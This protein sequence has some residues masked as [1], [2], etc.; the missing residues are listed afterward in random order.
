MDCFA[1]LAMTAEGELMRQMIGRT[2]PDL[3]P[4]IEPQIFTDL[5]AALVLVKHDDA[6]RAHI[7]VDQIEMQIGQKLKRLAPVHPQAR[8]AAQ[9]AAGFEAERLDAVGG[10]FRVLGVQREDAFEVVRVPG[11]D[12]LPAERGE[13][14]RRVVLALHGFLPFLPICAVQI[15]RWALERVSEQ[16][17]S[18]ILTYM[19]LSIPRRR[20]WAGPFSRLRGRA[21]S[22]I[23]LP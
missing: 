11:G 22:R 5:R 21:P 1:A 9:R 20:M 8:L 19:D 23:C 2:L 13:I 16:I 18:I 3:A 10:H 14:G 15:A 4:G 6:V 17:R 7:G 12:P